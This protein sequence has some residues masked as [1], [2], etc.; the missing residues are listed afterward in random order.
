MV[1]D[2]FL[3]RFVEPQTYSKFLEFRQN[4]EIA[5]SG[6]KKFCPRPQCQAVVQAQKEVKKVKCPT[7]SHDMCFQCVNP[8]HSGQTCEEAE[9]KMYK[10]WAMM[11]GASR[12]PNCRVLIEKNLGCK[13]MTCTQCKHEWCWICG[14]LWG[15]SNYH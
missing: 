13:H 2:E 15:N 11:K 12:C 3:K 5:M 4:H 10:G 14:G 6:E 7:C 9:R 8:W 1:P